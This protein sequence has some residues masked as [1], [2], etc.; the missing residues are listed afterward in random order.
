M[1]ENLRLSSVLASVA[2]SAGEAL[3]EIRASN[4]GID[5]E[6]FEVSLEFEG[7]FDFEGIAAVQEAAVRRK[8]GV[9]RFPGVKL[10]QY[11]SA[12]PSPAP[13]RS[14]FSRLFRPRVSD[15]PDSLSRVSIRLIM[16]PS[17]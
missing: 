15:D 10:M 12:T 4:G 17:E 6:E 7:E 3:D 16:S 5:L 14:L 9:R 13:K 2:E 1:A 8:E 11:R